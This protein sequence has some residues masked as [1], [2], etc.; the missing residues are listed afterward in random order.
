M[1]LISVRVKVNLR[2]TKALTHQITKI[3]IQASLRLM[4]RKN[5]KL[6]CRITRSIATKKLHPISSLKALVATPPISS[7][8]HATKAKD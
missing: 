6:T 2:A 8:T 4:E 5:M 3:I 1:T 7:K